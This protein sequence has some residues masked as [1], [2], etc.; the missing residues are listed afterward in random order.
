MRNADLPRPASLGRRLA[1]SVYDGLLVI[2]IWMSIAVVA[3]PVLAWL[4]VAT[5][6]PLQ[7][8]GIVGCW[9]YFVWSWSR[10]GQSLAMKAWRVRM[11]VHGA[12][13]APSMTR[14]SARF[15]VM[16]LL[17]ILPLTL[18]VFALVPQLEAPSVL[19]F[20]LLLPLAAMLPALIGARR[21]LVDLLA[22]TEVIRTPSRSPQP[23]SP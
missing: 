13:T 3:T 19:R 7:A 4:E 18:G 1:V 6:T 12:D 22:G 9:V 8:L 17:C 11:R 2:A 21:T 23:P 15:V 14:A 16:L 5:T 10:G 20:L